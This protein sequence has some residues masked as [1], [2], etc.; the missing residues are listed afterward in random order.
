MFIV[1]C[2]IGPIALFCSRLNLHLE[3]IFNVNY[4]YILIPSSWEFYFKIYS[5][6]FYGKLWIQSLGPHKP[7]S[8]T[9]C[10]I[11]IMIHAI[12][13]WISILL[14][15]QRQSLLCQIFSML[16]FGPQ[17]LGSHRFWNLSWTNLN[18]HIIMMRHSKNVTFILL[19]PEKKVFK[20]LFD[21]PF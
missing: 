17:R 11:K 18:L 20:D 7:W 14:L 8:P 4:N 9:L 15:N 13:I 5:N 12:Y 6:E 1:A 10:N 21:F 19:V 2:S 3:G 16:N